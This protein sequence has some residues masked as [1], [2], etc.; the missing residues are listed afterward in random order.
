MI[1]FLFVVAVGY[2]IDKSLVPQDIKAR[3]FWTF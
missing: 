1:T 3:L 2:P